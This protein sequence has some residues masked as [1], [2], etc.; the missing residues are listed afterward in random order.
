MKMLP[1][2][3]PAV[4]TDYPAYVHNCLRE[5]KCEPSWSAPIPG[6]PY[7][8]LY[9]D[10]GSTKPATIEFWLQ[11]VCANTSEQIFPF[12]YIVGQ[13]PEGNWY[14]VFK[15][16]SVPLAPV[17]TFVMWHSALVELG[18][19]LVEKTF[20]SEMLMV[21]PCAPLTKIKACQPELA[22]TT[23][24]DTNGVYYGLPVNVDYLGQT[25]VRFFH[26]AYVRLGKVRELSNKATFKASL[27]SN[28]RTTVEKIHQLETE[29]VPKWYKDELLAIYAR[30]V[31]QINDGATY[32][33]SD[34]NFEA[35]NDDD[36]TWKPFVQVKQ[37]FRLYYGCDASDCVE[38]CSPIIIQATTV[39]EHPSGSE[40]GGGSAPDPTIGF[41]SIFNN[42][43][44]TGGSANIL[45]VTISGGGP[46]GA[47]FPVVPGDATSGSYPAPQL[48][49]IQITVDG[50]GATTVRVIDSF[51]SFFD[52]AYIGAGTYSFPFTIINNSNFSVGII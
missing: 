13:T 44:T 7:L 9:V 33:C 28:F 16:F 4:M 29:L 21:E 8:Q 6:L 14:G 20:F 1:T 12:N 11:D 47:V 52:Q 31:I 45:N 27:I 18:D 40:S 5:A 43:D 10:Y 25:G 50:G 3:T 32:I 46:T 51:G 23:G 48:A 37:T 15:Y 42:A 17:T 24:F 26:I 30:G 22:T 41:A 39:T 35:L 2:P 49:T 36:L 38:C 19:G 34:L